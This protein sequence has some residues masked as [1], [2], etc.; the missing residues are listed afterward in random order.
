MDLQVELH[1]VKDLP[2]SE[3]LFSAEGPPAV[4]L[5]LLSWG[6][7]VI[8]LA[9]FAAPM[10]AHAMEASVQAA[11]LPPEVKEDA[12]AHQSHVLLYYAGTE[13]EA[14]GAG[15]GGLA[16]SVPSDQLPSATSPVA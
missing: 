2:E 9:C 15:A 14:L 5:G 1:L 16:V 8:R 13:P 7:H 11:L 10:P 3:S 12:R 4:Q 6:R